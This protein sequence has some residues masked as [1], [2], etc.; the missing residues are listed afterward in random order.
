MNDMKS[1]QELYQQYTAKAPKLLARISRLL[2]VCR[3]AGI[4]VPKGI[5]NIFE[6]S[7]EELIADPLI[8][9][10]SDILG[11]EISIGAP[12]EVLMEPAPVP[13]PV[14][15]KPPRPAPLLPM[16]S[17]ST[18]P[19]K[20]PMHPPQHG[21][22][23]LSSQETLQRF[24]RQSIH[25]LTELLAL[26]MKAMLES[27]SGKST[28]AGLPASYSFSLGPE[29]SGVGM[30]VC[31]HYTHSRQVLRMFCDKVAA[32]HMLCKWTPSCNHPSLFSTWSSHCTSFAKPRLRSWPWR[33][34]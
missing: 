22:Q 16:M 30:H 1:N 26:K 6:F 15:K 33:M 10:P 32:K 8:P 9:T 20:F 5:R 11:L 34:V 21:Y 19:A 28:K 12:P 31:V 23:E 17:A 13:A 7:W 4:S 2:L 24:Q 3:N 29:A 14:Q 18:G 27:I 25:L